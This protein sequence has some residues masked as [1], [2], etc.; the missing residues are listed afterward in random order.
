M[1][2]PTSDRYAQFLSLRY[3]YADLFKC[4]HDNIEQ[5]KE[6]VTFRSSGS[7]RTLE[8]ARRLSVPLAI[9]AIR[10]GGGDAGCPSAFTQR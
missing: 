2:S 8:L 4:T 7:R 5:F 10:S 1:F 3:H 6:L 9:D